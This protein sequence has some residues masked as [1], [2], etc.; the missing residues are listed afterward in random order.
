MNGLAWKL[1][2]AG[3]AVALGLVVFRTALAPDHR[4]R[5]VEFAPQMART[6][7]R[8]AFDASAAMP[9]GV[10]LHGPPAGVVLYGDTTPTY[11]PGDAEAARAGR[12]LRNP[13]AADDAAAAA[14]G[15]DVY[16]AKCAHCHAADGEGRT[17]ATERGMIPPPSLKGARALAMADGEM[18]H[19]VTHGRGNMAAHADVV[20]LEDRW[21]AVLR[22]RA[23]QK[24]PAK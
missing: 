9:Q 17:P 16:A 5:N 7:A 2:G 24:E 21:K 13:F 6:P 22:V 18:F 3:A 4:V 8:R 20:A 11:G 1:L 10:V 19:L 15:A 23:L 12:E 14:R